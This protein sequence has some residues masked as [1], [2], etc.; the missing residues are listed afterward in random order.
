MA[1]LYV[2]LAV[3]IIT[4]VTLSVGLLKKNSTLQ[5]FSAIGVGLSI[6]FLAMFQIVLG[7]H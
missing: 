3:L 2:I 5:L 7:G 1:S 6:M 4:L